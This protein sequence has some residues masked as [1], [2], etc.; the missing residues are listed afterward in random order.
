[1]KQYGQLNLPNG[2]LKEK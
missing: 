1:M 2:T